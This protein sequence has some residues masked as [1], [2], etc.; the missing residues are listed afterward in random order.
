MST[1]R[2]FKHARR[3]Q[4]G[5]VLIVALLMLMILSILASVSIRGASSTEQ[6]ANQSRQR[7]LAQQA[8]EAA[9]R[10]CET[11]VQAHALDSTKGFSPQAAPVGA[12]VTYSWQN[13]SNWDAIDA[14]VNPFV[15]TGA[16]KT[17][18][19]TASGD[20]GGKDYFTRKP[21]C[22]SQYLTPADQKVF[23]TTARGFG[24]EVGV[25]DGK[26]PNG[27][28]VWLQSVVTMK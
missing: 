26:V 10:F 24:P 18:A 14:G 9:L 20:A 11:Q 7:A 17:A 13:M 23:V 19:F 6:V 5:V 28:E 8:A 1:P 22:M 16:L 4:D 15:G 3:R 21:E 27:T 25:K 2:F 12:P